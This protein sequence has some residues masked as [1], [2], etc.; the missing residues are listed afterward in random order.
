VPISDRELEHIRRKQQEFLDALLVRKWTTPRLDFGEQ[1]ALEAGRKVGL[2]PI[3]VVE[4][5]YYWV[6]IGDLDKSWEPI[7]AKIQ[8]SLGKTP[9]EQIDADFADDSLA[10][11]A[12]VTTE[13]VTP[14]VFLCHAS[15]DKV[16]VRSYAARLA[17]AGFATWLDQEQLLPGQDWDL[18]I[19]KAIARSSAVIVFLSEKSRKRGYLQKEVLR[20]LDEAERQPEGTIFLIPAK[21]EPCEVPDR[22]S[23]WHWVDLWNPAGFNMLCK[24]LDTCRA[25]RP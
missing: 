5:L 19:R 11:R 13:G 24:A 16:A 4:F 17:D 23:R 8:Q 10:S 21:L 3:L 18:E 2:K 7:A 14:V 20:V 25:N 12:V 22:L 1:D 15:E 6:G 9:Y